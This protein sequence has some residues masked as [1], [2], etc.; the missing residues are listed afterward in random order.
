MP[1]LR[2]IKLTDRPVKQ[3]KEKLP[4]ELRLATGKDKESRI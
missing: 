3:I 2:V 4:A 1:E